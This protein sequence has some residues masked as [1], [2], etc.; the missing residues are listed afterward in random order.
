MTALA[1]PL[2]L[3]AT[4]QEM[5]R[6]GAEASRKIEEAVRILEEAGT[7]PDGLDFDDPSIIRHVEDLRRETTRTKALTGPPENLAVGTPPDGSPTP[8]L[9]V[10]VGRLVRPPRKPPRDDV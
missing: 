6:R 1:L 10:R 5:E 4:V 7:T 9:G 3:E 8:V 2:P